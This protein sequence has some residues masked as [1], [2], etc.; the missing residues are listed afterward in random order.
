MF[1]NR[2]SEASNLGRRRRSGT[3]RSAVYSSKDFGK[4]LLL[5]KLKQTVFPECLQHWSC[6]WCAKCALREQLHKID[7]YAVINRVGLNMMAVKLMTFLSPEIPFESPPKASTS[8]RWWWRRSVS[9]SDAGFM[10]I[11]SKQNSSQKFSSLRSSPFEAPVLMDPWGLHEEGMIS[12]HVYLAVI[13]V[14]A[15]SALKLRWNKRRIARRSAES[16]LFLSCS[17]LLWRHGIILCILIACL[18][19]FP[20]PLFAR[21]LLALPWR[22]LV[23]WKSCNLQCNASD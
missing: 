4:G 15:I 23:G 16:P 20:F 6:E 13:K 3:Q 8:R 22:I 14:N 7:T 12:W 2:L 21:W 19:P 5:S 17:I 10:E 11:L 1:A 18:P 9:L